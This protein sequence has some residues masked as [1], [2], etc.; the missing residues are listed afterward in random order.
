MKKT[1]FC[2]LFLLLFVSAAWSA[3]I[4]DISGKWSLAL[5][6]IPAATITL[7][8]DPDPKHVW[9]ENVSYE[10]EYTAGSGSCPATAFNIPSLG[11]TVIVTC[12]NWQIE[13]DGD[14]S[15]DN[16]VMAGDFILTE[17][18]TKTKGK[19]TMERKTCWL[20]EGCKQ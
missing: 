10:G 8:H 18:N 11:P 15:N 7:T 19:F 17:G 14:L 12:P 2:A 13:L 5:N 16:S 6:G 9:N 1:T 20:P 3:T 4:A